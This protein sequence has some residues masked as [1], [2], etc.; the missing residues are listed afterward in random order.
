L[1]AIPPPAI[2]RAI[3]RIRA[4]AGIA[5]FFPASDILPEAFRCQELKHSLRLLPLKFLFG[6][7]PPLESFSFLLVQFF[8]WHLG[9]S[10]YGHVQ[11]HVGVGLDVAVAD[12]VGVAVGVG[13]GV[14]LG[15]APENRTL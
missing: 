2:G 14:G 8:L 6:F 9:T 13:F 7:D 1:P 12:G 11:V 4:S 15:E 5:M 3:K 10:F